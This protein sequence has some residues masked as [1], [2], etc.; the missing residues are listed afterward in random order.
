MCRRSPK[1]PFHRLFKFHI[2]ASVTVIL[3]Q[4]LIILMKLA[5][6]D[7]RLSIGESL[8]MTYCVSG[9][10]CTASNTVISPNFLVWTFCGKA[11][12]PQNFG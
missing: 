3:K 8:W 5:S 6:G 12:F 1:N 4:V 2:S 10:N 11:Q 9:T 7:F